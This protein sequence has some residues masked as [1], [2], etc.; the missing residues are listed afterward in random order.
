[1]LQGSF[2]A[3]AFVLCKFSDE[4]KP[5]RPDLARQTQSGP[6]NDPDLAESGHDL[7]KLRVLAEW[8][9]QFLGPAERGPQL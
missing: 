8:A 9:N 2:R 5:D 4:I 7:L 3:N 1:M 6:A